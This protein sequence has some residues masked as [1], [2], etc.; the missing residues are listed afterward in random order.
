[1]SATH[2]DTTAQQTVTVTVTDQPIIQRFVANP[3]IVAP[4]GS[5]TLAWDTFNATSVFLNGNAVTGTS[6]IVTP[7]ATTTYTLTA[8]NPQGIATSQLTLLVL[9]PGVPRISEFMANNDGALIAD[10]DHE[11]SDWIEI[12]NPSGTP[13][14]LQGYFL[15]DDPADLRKWAFPSVTLAPNGYLIVFASGK[16][17]TVPGAPLHTNFS[18]DA[19]G[20]YLALV[21]PDGT[22]VFRVW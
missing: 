21:K 7:T 17:R 22:I 9:E 14:Q 2:P 1:M 8:V 15:T 3:A 11:F 18:L 5:A 12:H 19:D 10:E 20:E 4:G 6:T 13:A 16:N